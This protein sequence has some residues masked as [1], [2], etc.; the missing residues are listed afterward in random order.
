MFRTR[1]EGK[2]AAVKASTAGDEGRE[3]AVSF[4]W[5]EI[6]VAGVVMT[7]GALSTDGEGC[8][9]YTSTSTILAAGGRS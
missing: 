8:V 9:L 3:E 2:L 5:A 4:F 7:F 1:L 6:M